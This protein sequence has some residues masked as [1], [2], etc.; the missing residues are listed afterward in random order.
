LVELC[1][2]IKEVA[3]L[4]TIWCYTGFLYEKIKNTE[5]INYIDILIDGKYEE[6]LNWGPGKIKWRGSENQRIIDVKKTK[7]TGVLTV[8][9]DEE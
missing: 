7:W 6:S 8:L 9:K 4:K 3:P 2:W 5:L 1:K